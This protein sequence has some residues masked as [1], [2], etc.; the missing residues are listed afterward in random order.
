MDNCGTT[1]NKWKPISKTY[2]RK[3]QKT[4]IPSNPISSGGATVNKKLRSF[5][6]DDFV[7]LKTVATTLLRNTRWTT[8][9]GC[10]ITVELA[11]YERLLKL[12]IIFRRYERQYE[13]T[14]TSREMCVQRTQKHFGRSKVRDGTRRYGKVCYCNL[15]SKKKIDIFNRSFSKT[16]ANPAP[17]ERSKI[18]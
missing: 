5:N 6:T 13:Q 4:G 2:F 7:G 10:T 12:Q 3:L 18:Q 8:V 14:Q 15:F 9:N 16:R 11:N 17:S 1:R